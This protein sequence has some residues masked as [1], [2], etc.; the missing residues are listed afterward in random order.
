MLLGISTTG[1]AERQTSVSNTDTQIRA[2][3]QQ[4]AGMRKQLSAAR[5]ELAAVG[6]ARQTVQLQ[7]GALQRQIEALKAEVGGLRASSIPDLN[8]YLT[9][10]VSNGY[11][12][13]LFRGIN[14]QIVNGMGET[15]SVNGTGN[16]IV[17][18]NRPGVSNATCSV[19]D[20]GVCLN[21]F[22]KR[23]RVGAKS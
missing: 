10:D 14:V 17:G 15:Q 4:V 23:R 7:L 3:R 1:M 11:P 6:T 2:L 5:S 9:F 20:H 22:G 16:L 19:G 13:A 21:M 12:T 8:G 18:Y